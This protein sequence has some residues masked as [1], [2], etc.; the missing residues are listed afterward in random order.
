MDKGYDIWDGMGNCTTPN[1]SSKLAKKYPVIKEQDMIKQADK[2]RGRIEYRDIQLHDYSGL[3]YGN[4]TMS[5]LDGLMDF[6]G[7][8]F[9]YVE[10]KY[11]S[12]QLSYGQNLALERLCD[13]TERG[14]VPSVLI[15]ASHEYKT[16]DIDGAGALV[17]K[18]RY[19]GKWQSPNKHL[20][21][22]E[23]FDIMLAKFK[24]KE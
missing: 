2:D 21:V 20:T 24:I 18:Y 5:D 16:G 15:V 14:G 11:N 8:L 12:S 19:K 22:R 6:G 13:A 4:K 1:Y 23:A 3:R 10:Y 7:K 17:L 9:I